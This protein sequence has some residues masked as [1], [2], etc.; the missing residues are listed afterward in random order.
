[1]I[2]HRMKHARR[3][4]AT[5]ELALLA[6][7]LLFLL[8]G[9]WEVGRGV[10]VQNILDHAAREGGR[11]AAS[12]GFMSSNNNGSPAGGTITL[13]P[14]S[15]NSNCEVQQKVFLYLQAAGVS[16]TGGTVQV[17]NNGTTASPKTWSYKQTQA[18]AITGSGYDP[19]AAA[20]QL[21]QLIVT[22]T[23]PYTNVGWSPLNWFFSSGTTLTASSTWGSMRDLPLTISTTIPSRP[24]QPSDPLP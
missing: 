24:I 13:N 19:A 11:I 5:T 21:D 22:V 8:V 23:L 18:G 1:M 14:P 20:D 15:S 6:P 10:M 9:L 4:V 12:G 3:G 2:L 7:V 17:Q 16:T